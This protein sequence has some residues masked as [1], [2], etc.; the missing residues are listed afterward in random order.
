M[1]CR[2]SFNQHIAFLNDISVLNNQVTSLRNQ[3][4]KRLAFLR[5]NSNTLFGFIVLTKFNH[6]VDV[7]NNSGIFRTAGFKQFSHTRQ[8]TGNIFGLRAFPRN[9][10]DNVTDFDI[11]TIIN[12]QNSIDRQVVANFF[13][14]IISNGLAI[15]VFQHDARFQTGTAGV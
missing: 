11:F 4:F 5:N 3:I 10:R 13:A 15:A 8:T 2:S 14:I 1:R 7:G 6:T 12:S 9:T